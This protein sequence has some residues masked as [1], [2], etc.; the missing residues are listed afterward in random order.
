[1]KRQRRALTTR[2]SSIPP[3]GV[4]ASLTPKV[5]PVTDGD[6][7]FPSQ[8]SSQLDRT[9]KR[10]LL[11]DDDDDTTPGDI[12]T[13]T[14]DIDYTPN[15]QADPIPVPSSCW[16]IQDAVNGN[17]F[18][19]DTQQASTW[20]M[21][22]CVANTV[23]VSHPAVSANHVIVHAPAQAD[24]DTPGSSSSS[25]QI[26]PL[27]PIWYWDDST[28]TTTTGG[29]DGGGQQQQQQQ[30][31]RWKKLDPSSSRRGG[32]G[33][34]G[35]CTRLLSNQQRFR[36]LAPTKD[37]SNALV[38]GIE[39]IV[40]DPGASAHQAGDAAA[41]A[42]N[43]SF[44]D[45]Y[46]QLLQRVQTRGI[47]GSNKKGFNR[48]LRDHQVLVIDLSTTTT[49]TNEE[50]NR[51][52][53]LTLRNMYKGD[54]AILELLWYLRGESHV[55]FLREVGCP[56]WDPQAEEDGFVGLNYGLL[57]KFPAAD[58]TYVNQLEKLVLDPLCRGESSRNMLCTL[59]HPG[60]RTVQN[61]CSASVQFAVSNNDILDL[62]VTQRSSD[63]LLGLPYDVFIFQVLLHLVRREV[64][65]RSQRI[66]RA[67]KVVFCINAGGA[68]VY[69][70][71]WSNLQTLLERKPCTTGKGHAALVI[72]GNEGIFEMARNYKTTGGPSRIYV[73]G[74]DKFHPAMQIEQAL[75]GNNNDPHRP[76]PP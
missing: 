31:Q 46:W 44:D 28:T 14:Q 8:S 16:S 41:A 6:D 50:V 75:G 12:I 7:F 66:L 5:S 17:M 36:L 76:G 49:T 56:F 2:A 34:G 67:G 9:V 74:Y 1:M 73:T 19:F 39:W 24:D 51:V 72:E 25:L 40:H 64:R 59:L 47:P 33:G 71:N 70:I 32:G 55:Q 3:Q 15:S 38:P 57:T 48:T 45:Q 61:A 54:K 22:R 65:R 60:E 30:Q 43:R 13:Q 53:L 35:C 68:H 26:A 29:D 63:I 37:S 69:D 4:S 58:G 21:G 10:R 11:V 20:T 23:V 62:T 27:K 18:S 52:Q 42:S